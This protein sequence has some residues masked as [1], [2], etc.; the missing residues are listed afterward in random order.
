MLSPKEPSVL[1]DYLM[2]CAPPSPTGQS[3]SI[4]APL[5]TKKLLLNYVK[6]EVYSSC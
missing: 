5:F 4:H 2:G 1:Y 3:P 6:Q